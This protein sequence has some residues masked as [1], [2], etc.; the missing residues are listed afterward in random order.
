MKAKLPIFILEFTRFGETC[1]EVIQLVKGYGKAYLVPKT[2]NNGGVEVMEAVEKHKYRIN[3]F[4]VCGVNISY[5][6]AE[7]IEELVNTYKKHIQVVT[8]A[9]NCTHEKGDAFVT[10]GNGIYQNEFVTLVGTPEQ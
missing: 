5:C 2:M 8:A 10:R 3:N 6:V 1:P 9:C 4:I 7:T